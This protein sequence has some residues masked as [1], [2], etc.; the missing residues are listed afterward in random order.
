MDNRRDFIKKAALLSGAAGVFSALPGSIQR[1]LAI[2]P[3]PG[4]TFLDAEHIV[5]LMQE[6]RSFDHCYGTLK[7]VRGYDDPRA[8]RLPDNN[9]VWLQSNGQGETYAPF[10]LN[11]KDTKATWMS[12]LP[13]SWTNQVDARNNGKYDQW[14]LVKQSGN[15]EWAPMPLTMGFYNREDIP[16]YYSLADAFTVCDQNFCSSLTGT[17]PN[18]LYLWT[19]TLRDE[20]TAAAKANVWNDDVDY[21]AEAHWVSFPERLE[22]HGVSWKIYQNEISAAG[23]EGEKDGMLANFTDNPIE[24][25]AAFNVRFA[26]GHIQYLQRQVAALT[27]A[28]LALEDKLK[29]LTPGSEDAVK[30]QRDLEKKKAALEKHQKDATTFT[31]ANFAK[32]SPRAQ[33]LHQKAFT[34]NIGDPDYH[35]LETLQYQDGATARTVNVPKGDILHQFRKDVHSGQL[36]TVS[37]LVAPGEFSDHPGAPWY[38]AWY[39]S[40]VLDI[41]TKEEAV[42]KKTIFILCYDENDGYFDHV[43]PFVA[44]HQPGTGKVSAGIDT[45]V[46]YVTKAME[47][48]KKHV[49]ATEVR[50]SPVGLGYRV[51]LVIAS[52][53]SRGGYV[54][55]QV[56]DHTSILQF[57]ERFLQHKTGKPIQETNISAWRRTVCG[58]LTSVFRP[59]NGEKITVPFP[60]RNT[61]IESVYNAKFKKLPDGFKKL[62]PAEIT[63]IN[64]APATAEWMP[65]QEKGQRASC[66]LPYEL[67]A[68]G[69]LRAD[70]TAFDISFSAANTIFGKQAAGAPFN[71]YA[72]GK[73]VQADSGKMEAVRTW[74]Y[75]VTAGDQLKDSWP[76]QAFADNRYHLC[77]Y[78]PNGFFREFAG[79]VHDPQ[80]EIV[81]AYQP[82]ALHSKK[83]TGNVAL[84]LINKSNQ[85]V[86]IQVTDMAYGKGNWKK[87]VAAH[88][89]VTLIIDLATSHGWYDFA[90]QVAGQAS[91]RQRY[92]G[93]VET[94]KEGF[95]D[96]VI[97]A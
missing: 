61:F 17:T 47:Q 31:A 86:V 65:R 1:A 51:P 42:W 6:N 33:Q 73:Y 97:G 48:A 87:T 36:P 37:W 32:L 79:D 20:Q 89:T 46:E 96:P 74:S 34:T 11:I 26:T 52:P 21:G 2:D 19:G 40:E 92:A 69:K 67:Y 30:L 4:S 93:R 91:F 44:P 82:T 75:A 54:N 58:D 71:V 18:R 76:L 63:A 64:T 81:C 3:R 70:K 13:H 84:Q 41:L 56:F 45:G 78:G 66:A 72:P 94:G 68:S 95:S 14:L 39:V 38:G 49:G 10:R 12:S 80:V 16:F 85:P 27:A 59:F 28:I 83:L 23:L 90:V 25:F 7:G 55:S 29:T 15:K 22:D 9:L 50:E 5:I 62:T 53:W 77:V 24:W 60:E 8:I 57:M 88:G 43:P 35:E